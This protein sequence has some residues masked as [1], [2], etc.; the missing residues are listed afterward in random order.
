MGRCGI[1]TY[2]C[3]PVRSVSQDMFRVLTTYAT[4]TPPP[5]QRQTTGG[6]IAFF[7]F[8][9]SSSLQPFVRQL[10]GIQHTAM[11]QVATK[12]K[13]NNKATS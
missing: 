9:A 1:I 12:N 11:H 3:S 10:L 2:E 13:N 6:A 4:A 7:L 8:F 5:P